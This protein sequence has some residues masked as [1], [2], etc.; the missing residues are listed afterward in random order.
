MRITI[1][2][3]AYPFRG[4]IADTNEAMC[5][6]FMDAGHVVNIVSFSMQYPGFL[7]PGKTQ[8]SEDPDPEGLEISLW[9]HSLNPLNWIKTA[10][11]INKLEPDLVIFRHWIPFMAP[12]FGTIARFLD[13]KIK[14][15]TL[16]D[17]LYPHEKR[18]LDRLLTN[19]LIRK[20]DGFIVFSNT[21]KQQLESLGF[22]NVLFTPH[23]LVGKPGETV[24][25]AEACDFLG[26]DSRQNYVLFF[27]LVRKYKGLDLLLRSFADNSLK[28]KDIRLIVAGEFYDDPGIYHSL[29]KEHKLGGRVVLIN[30]FIPASEIRY[31]FAAASLVAQT[32]HTATQSGITQVAY[33]Y[34]MPM[35]VTNV[36]GL[37]EY[38]PDGRVGYIVE[39]DEGQIAAAIADFFDNNRYREFSE[40]VKREKMKYSWDI[41]TGRVE[42]LYKSLSI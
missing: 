22:G 40:G 31:Y 3:P 24:S 33:N 10:A 18:P 11:K 37:S 19:Y 17:N 36:G 39:K 25:K 30:K 21:V 28:G 38:V 7:F 16:V 12:A 34:N 5:R 23:P 42:E 27:G 13:K 32:Y 2:G 20:N 29:I 15:F 8:M 41:F 9:I 26:L 6:S 1:I 35:L 14:I 4:G